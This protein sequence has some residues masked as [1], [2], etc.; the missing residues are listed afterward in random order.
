[1]CFL[2]YPFAKK[3]YKLYDLASKK[4]FVS[5]D[6]VFHE[7]CFPFTTS[8]NS[9]TIST[10]FPFP[11]PIFPSSDDQDPRTHTSIPASPSVPSPVSNS[12]PPEPVPSTSTLNFDPDIPPLLPHNL[13]LG[14]L[15]DIT[16]LLITSRTMCVNFLLFLDPLLLLLLWNLNLSIT[17]KLL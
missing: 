4:C 16:T 9:T 3:G 5:R 11:P 17:L 6:V 15:L 8:S 13:M 12:L 7:K 1:M 2:G 14:D 10:I